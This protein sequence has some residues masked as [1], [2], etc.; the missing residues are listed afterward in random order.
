MK[1]FGIGRNYV[2]HIEELNNERPD[3][4]VIFLMPDTALLKNNQPF[5]YPDFSKDIHY[6]VELVLK[7]CQKGKNIKPEF[8]Y[9]YYD[10]IGVGIDF[11]ARDLQQQA[12]EK[13]CHGQSPKGLM[14]PPLFLISNPYLILM[15]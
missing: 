11:T 6:E 14:T 1:I 4:P 10:Q 15:P 9:K 12:K 5:Y 3:E 13:V 8:A 2:E 7:I